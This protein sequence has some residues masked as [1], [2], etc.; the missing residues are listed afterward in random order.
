[1]GLSFRGAS[2]VTHSRSVWTF[3]PQVTRAF[4]L[5]HCADSDSE[6]VRAWGSHCLE[7][8]VPLLL[9][10]AYAVLQFCFFKNLV[11]PSAL[12]V[13]HGAPI[14]NLA[15]VLALQSSYETQGRH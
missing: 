8:L 7:R 1:M 2:C 15:L 9:L 14:L 5:W 11:Y 12:T 6:A 10:E 3:S 4:A 13:L